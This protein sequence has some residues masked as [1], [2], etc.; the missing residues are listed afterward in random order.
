MVSLGTGPTSRATPAAQCCASALYR[1]GG[2]YAF[3]GTTTPCDYT[4]YLDFSDL[5]STINE[6]TRYFL[7]LTDY[8]KGSA[9][10]LNFCEIYRVEGEED[11]YLAA[12][13]SMP[14]SVD[15]GTICARIDSQVKTSNQPPVANIICPETTGTVPL[16]VQFDGGTSSDPDGEIT[17]CSW[18]FGDGFTAAGASVQ[19]TYTVSGTFT[20]V[21]SVTDNGGKTNTASIVV[22]V[23][24]ENR[25][26][27]ARISTNAVQ[28]EAPLKITF[29]GSKSN[30][31]D[32]KITGYS[33][34][35]GDGSKGSG[36]Y[37]NHS[38]TSAGTYTAVLTVTDN[39]GATGFASIVIKA[40]QSNQ[41]PVARISASKISGKIPFSVTLS[42]LN[43]NDADGKISSYKWNFGDGYTSSSARV[44]HTYRTA[45]TFTVTLT[46]TDN[47]KATGTASL[48]ITA[49]PSNLSPVASIIAST[50]SGKAPLAISFSGL[51]SIDPDGRIV[52]YRW[53]FGDGYTMTGSRVSHTYRKTGKFTVTLTVIDNKGASNS[54]TTAITVN[55]LSTRR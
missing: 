51:N 41:A 42:G 19:H 17:S 55:S 13:E 5:D 18:D 28:G 25:T 26:P 31:P 48:V 38:Y 1:A 12:A 32:G 9:A 16:T 44:S 11:R 34:D 36:V 45:G 39:G 43:S 29:N 49:N 20:A 47:K 4:F 3:D 37:L 10:I 24:P 21:L 22:N 30:D 27:V 7:G 2:D 6:D 46:V 35:F 52:S 40:L 53:N 14:Q 50:A 33:W 54:C 23:L 15:A 8:L